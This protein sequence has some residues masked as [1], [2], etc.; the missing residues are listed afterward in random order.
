LR[1]EGSPV[2]PRP[3]S[4]PY[5]GPAL[6]T[7]NSLG[8]SKSGFGGLGLRG[9]RRPLSSSPPAPSL[10]DVGATGSHREHA[11]NEAP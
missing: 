7:L 6:D 8:G 10:G 2:D 4:N 3:Q 1:S 5:E 9:S 11:Q